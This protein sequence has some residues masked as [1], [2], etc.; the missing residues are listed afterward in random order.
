MKES[1]DPSAANPANRRKL[2]TRKIGRIV[3]TMLQYR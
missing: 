2:I 1:Q 3:R